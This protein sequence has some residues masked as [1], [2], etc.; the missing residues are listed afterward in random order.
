MLRSDKWGTFQNH[1]GNMTFEFATSVSFLMTMVV[2]IK[3]QLKPSAYALFSLIRH[4]ELIF[5]FCS[6]E[7]PAALTSVVQIAGILKLRK[8]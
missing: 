4:F 1:F 5:V 6:V 7:S 8:Y 3:I 2:G